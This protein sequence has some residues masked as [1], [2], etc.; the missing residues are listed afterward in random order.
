[1]AKSLFWGL[2]LLSAFAI[3]C[4]CMF[5][6]SDSD[7]IPVELDVLGEK[8]AWGDLDVSKHKWTPMKWKN[9]E[10]A[11]ADLD[12]SKHKWKHWE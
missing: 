12:V 1:M 3:I 2:A 9:D 6:L 8:V 10:N 7:D 11:W 5:V 4:T